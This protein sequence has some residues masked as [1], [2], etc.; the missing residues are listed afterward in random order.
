MGRSPRTRGSP[1]APRP[2]AD[3]PAA[4]SSTRGSTRC[5]GAPA[6]RTP[7]HAPC[8]VRRDRRAAGCRSGGEVEDGLGRLVREGEGLRAGRDVE[9]DREVRDD[10]ALVGDRPAGS[11]ERLLD[12]RVAGRRA[13][14]LA[15]DE[16]HAGRRDE[17]QQRRGDRERRRRARRPAASSRACTPIQAISRSSPSSADTISRTWAG[18]AAWRNVPH[19]VE[20][21]KSRLV[22]EERRRPTGSRAARGDRSRTNHG[23][24]TSPMSDVGKPG[25]SRTVNRLWTR[26]STR[27]SRSR[28]GP[29]AR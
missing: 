21:G 12:R 2:C 20:T 24:A 19:V 26:P 5:P 13:P 22:N 25:I 29:T 14:R 23:S 1:R 9:P 11:R 18:P 4:P 10:R 6:S 3:R 17:E 8:W 28:A 27:I 16:R 7:G 15:A